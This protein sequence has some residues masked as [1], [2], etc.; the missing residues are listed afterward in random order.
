MP[1]AGGG[2]AGAGVSLEGTGETLAAPCAGRPGLG[3]SGLVWS[4]LAARW[5]WWGH[6]FLYPVLLSLTDLCLF[7][8]SLERARI[9]SGRRRCQSVKRTVSAAGGPFP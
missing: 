9:R 3:E 1:G 8:S 6:A 2:E 5:G 4:A 7:S